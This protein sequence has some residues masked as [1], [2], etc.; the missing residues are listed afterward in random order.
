MEPVT[1]E[2]TFSPEVYVAMQMIGL[3]KAELAAEMKRATAINLFRRGLLSIGKA[4]EL[5]DIS[6][7]DIMG[8]LAENGLALAEYSMDDLVHDETIFGRVHQ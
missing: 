2:V 7:A 6:L 5:A 1:V 8:L 3:E 4:A